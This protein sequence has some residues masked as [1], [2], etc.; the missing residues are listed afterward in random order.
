LGVPLGACSATSQEGEGVVLTALF[1]ERAG[2]IEEEFGAAV[3][4][5]EFVIGEE[6]AFLS[7]GAAG[8]A[9]PLDAAF[10]VEVLVAVDAC[11][12]AGLVCG[13]LLQELEG[14][15]WGGPLFEHFAAAPG[16]GEELEDAEV[17]EGLAGGVTD[18][19]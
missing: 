12:V 13:E 2:R 16:V 15:G 10:L 5:V 3:G 8:G 19:F 18:L 1:G 6:A 11:D 4:G 9:G 17:G 14:G 7:R